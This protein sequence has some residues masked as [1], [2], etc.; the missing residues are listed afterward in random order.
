LDV[1]SYFVEI[2]DSVAFIGGPE[3]EQVLT[4]ID[5]S[6]PLNPIVIGK[7]QDV[8]G[9][10]IEIEG[11]FA[12]LAG[13]DGIQIVDIGDPAAMVLRSVYHTC[14]GRCVHPLDLVVVD[15]ILYFVGSYNRM[16]DVFGVL[17]VSNPDAPIVLNDRLIS[18]KF[19][20]LDLIGTT[21]YMTAETNGQLSAFDISN[22][23]DIRLLRTQEVSRRVGDMDV[24]IAGDQMVVAVVGG[25]ELYDVGEGCGPCPADINLDGQLDSADFEAWLDA[26]QSRDISADQNLDRRVRSNDFT[27][28]IANFNNGCDF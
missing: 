2:A 21:A 7:L 9:E 24:S 12:Y 15:N 23:S 1:G 3:E 27:A 28:W 14:N 20:H 18:G 11:S 25:I 10:A 5:V 4:A 17:D 19:Q 16:S 26:Y 22:P 13:Q 6:N 8:H